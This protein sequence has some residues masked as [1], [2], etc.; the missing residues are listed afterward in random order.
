MSFV[1][2]S[3]PVSLC[4]AATENKLGENQAEV[5]RSHQDFLLKAWELF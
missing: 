3:E 2:D 1:S 5:T 4:S